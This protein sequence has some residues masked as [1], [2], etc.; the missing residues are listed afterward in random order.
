MRVH[1]RRGKRLVM[2]LV[3]ALV[4]MLAIGVLPAIAV[5]IR[6][7]NGTVRDAAGT[8][9]AGVLVS[10]T[11]R[12]TYTDWQGKYSLGFSSL[13]TYAIT[14]SRSDLNSQTK[15]VNVATQVGPVDFSLAYKLVGAIDD[16]AFNSVP[17]TLT[18]TAA[19]TAPS[20]SC[21]T[22]TVQPSGTA[23]P[24]AFTTTSPDG[25][26]NWAGTYT[27]PSGTADGSYAISYKAVQCSG[28]LLL[29]NLANQTYF[30]DRIAPSMDIKTLMPL[31]HGNS[32]FSGQPLLVKVT[33]DRSGVN[34]AS[35]TFTLTDETTGSTSSFA[36]SAVSYN[37]TTGWAK[38]TPATLVQGHVYRTS[39]TLSDFAGNAANL[40]HTPGDT[41]GG[42]LSST[43]GLTSAKASIPATT[44]TLSG[45]NAQTGKKTATCRSVPLHLDSTL[46]TLGGTRHA[47]FGYVEQRV[48]LN[49]AKLK[50]TLAGVQLTQAAYSAADAAWSPR[51]LSTQFF[52]LDRGPATQT[53]GIAEVD[54]TIGTLTVSVPATWSS[55]TLFMDPVNSAPSSAACADPSVS[56]IACVPDSVRFYTG[57]LAA[58]QMKADLALAG[59][60]PGFTRLTYPAV[61][62]PLPQSVTCKPSFGPWLCQPA[63]QPHWQAVAPVGGCLGSTCAP[64]P[65]D[66]SVECFLQYSAG[67]PAITPMS[68]ADTCGATLVDC[69]TL[70][71]PA[72]FPSADDHETQ[73]Q[74]VHMFPS[75]NPYAPGD[76]SLNGDA[77][78]IGQTNRYYSDTVDETTCDHRHRNYNGPYLCYGFRD[79]PGGVDGMAVSWEGDWIAP[80]DQINPPY[81]TLLNYSATAVQFADGFQCFY[82]SGSGAYRQFNWMQWDRGNYLRGGLYPRDWTSGTHGLVE[83]T[84]NYSGGLKAK[85]EGHYLIAFDECF[86]GTYFYRIGGRLERQSFLGQNGQVRIQF[87]HVW[88]NTTWNWSVGGSRTG[89]S[90]SVSPSNEDEH[91]VVRSFSESYEY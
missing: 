50:T 55:A 62:L 36:S 7:I 57:D 43:I 38:T 83:V 79:S 31:D 18:L 24:L 4:V 82:P 27:V 67:Y 37:S 32:I 34:P 19:S 40:A 20:S 69:Y 65:Q 44:C 9:L 70:D 3:L 48:T 53:V 63:A 52:V 58:D 74:Y 76:A 12:S 15:N 2:G 33:D 39:V 29:T 75:Y 42:F 68:Y 84:D 85:Q 6:T 46:M 26:N 80:P 47:G 90:F 10:Y 59:D 87:N 8:P 22:A 72:A 86:W 88:T 71:E 11:S 28:G 73:K 5:D 45:V 51:S 61:H 60:T 13:G 78:I 91:F 56:S 21:A 66:G 25:T 89:P 23:V 16:S 49:T 81:Y 17:K 1:R 30:L 14:A 64:C 41:G 77:F 54:A 35:I